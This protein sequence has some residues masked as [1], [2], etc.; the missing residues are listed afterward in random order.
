MLGFELVNGYDPNTESRVWAL[1]S[2]IKKNN[3]LNYIRFNNSIIAMYCDCKIFYAS[4]VI[5][6]LVF[7]F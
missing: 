1:I 3:L 2:I 7:F 5:R 4:D 6:A